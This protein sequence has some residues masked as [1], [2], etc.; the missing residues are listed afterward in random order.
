[1]DGFLFQTLLGSA[2]LA[3]LSIPS[4]G[5]FSQIE[6]A[7]LWVSEKAEQALAYAQET[8]TAEGRETIYLSVSGIES[9]AATCISTREVARRSAFQEDCL[10]ALNAVSN[11]SFHLSTDM[12][13]DNSVRQ[14]RLLAAEFLCRAIW[15]ETRT[16]DIPFNPERCRPQQVVATSTAAG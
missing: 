3:A 9:L 15:A 10:E 16:A 8:S 12:L 14:N 13:D 4:P 1:M 7:K 6:A 2:I 5:E 11:V